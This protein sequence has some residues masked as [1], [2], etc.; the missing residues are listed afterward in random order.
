MLKSLKHQLEPTSK[1]QNSILWLNP[2]NEFRLNFLCLIP[3][4]LEHHSQSAQPS[5]TNLKQFQYSLD[6][7]TWAPWHRG[8]TIV[9]LANAAVDNSVDL[10]ELQYYSVVG[11]STVPF[12]IY[13]E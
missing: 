11:P 1:K 4:R 6:C 13:T 8:K 7:Y 3:L 12:F 10:C 5:I 9:Q 2:D